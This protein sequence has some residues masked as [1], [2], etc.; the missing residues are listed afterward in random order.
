MA[1]FCLDP[2]LLLGSNIEGK[3][4][5]LLSALSTSDAIGQRTVVVENVKMLS[6]LSI[7]IKNLL[8]TDATDLKKTW[9]FAG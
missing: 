1:G 7:A 6:F 4:K 2:M 3:S 9:A 8:Q 5:R